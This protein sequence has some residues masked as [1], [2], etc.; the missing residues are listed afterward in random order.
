[1]AFSKNE[2]QRR[3]EKCQKE[4]KDACIDV[5]L[6]T[7]EKNIYYLSGYRTSLLRNSNFRLFSLMI[8]Q[9]GEPVLIVPNLEIGAARIMSWF[10]DVRFWGPEVSHRND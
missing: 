2:Y 5:L 4:M 3:L 6:L 7:S 8:F 1:M 10:K 9:T